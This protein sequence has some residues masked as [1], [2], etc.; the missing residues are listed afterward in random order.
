MGRT[1][2][3]CHVEE[4]QITHVNTLTDVMHNSPFTF[5]EYSME[6]EEKRLSLQ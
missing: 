4:F 2:K 6:K 3:I 1:E 5:K